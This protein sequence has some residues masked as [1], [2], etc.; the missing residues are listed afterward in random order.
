LNTLGLGAT[1]GFGFAGDGCSVTSDLRRFALRSAGA[2]LSFFEGA[3]TGSAFR[4]IAPIL[5]L[6]VVVRLFCCRASELRRTFLTRQ[7]F[8]RLEKKNWGR[9]V[10]EIC[11]EGRCETCAT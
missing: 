8:E 10:G 1:S 4:F 6:G 3:L 2:L 5:S 11:A 9:R 7:D